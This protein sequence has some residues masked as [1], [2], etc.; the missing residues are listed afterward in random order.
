ME[1]SLQ[2]VW[3]E[4]LKP[5]PKGRKTKVKHNKKKLRKL[6]NNNEIDQLREE[7]TKKN[8]ELYDAKL[9]NEISK[10]SMN[11][12]RNLKGRKKTQIVDQIR[13]EQESLPKSNRYKVGDILKTIGLKKATYHDERKRI[14]DYVDKYED[15]KVEILKI[16]ESGRYRRRL[17]YGYRRVQEELIKLDIHLI[18]VQLEKWPVTF[19][20]SIL[21]KPYLSK[22]YIPMLHKYA[23]PILSGL[24]FQ[25]LLTKQ[26]RKF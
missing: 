18:K 6:V 3:Y 12:V 26:A 23:W 15:V 16:A 9:E 19:Y 7:L 13:V 21:M 5:H 4:A 17:T 20:I 1:D 11:A 14:K 24:T 2:S 25:L 10:K 8:Q 22:Y